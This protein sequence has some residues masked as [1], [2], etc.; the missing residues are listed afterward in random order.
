MRAASRAKAIARALEFGFPGWLQC[1]FDDGLHAPVADGG[2]AKWTLFAVGFGNVHSTGRF[3]LP[4][5]KGTEIINKFSSGLRCLDDHLI[6]TCRMPTSVDL[7]H[8]PHAR[9][10]VAVASQH[11]LLERPH[12]AVVARL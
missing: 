11:E 6:Y 7:R 9:E 8:S 10:R 12:R 3:S 4:R 1:I 2:D 5:L